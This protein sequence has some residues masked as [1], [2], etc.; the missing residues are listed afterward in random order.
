MP[1]MVIYF[2]HEKQ[3]LFFCEYFRRPG[4]VIGMGW[5][6]KLFNSTALASL[7]T[8]AMP[9][10]FLKYLFSFPNNFFENYVYALV[11]NHDFIFVT[12]MYKPA[13]MHENKHG[14]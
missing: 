5:N 4:Q 9:F 8:L 10:S 12:C 11:V 7:E 13:C 1:L 6:R 14:V 3:Y 2:D